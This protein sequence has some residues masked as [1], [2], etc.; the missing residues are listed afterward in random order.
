MRRWHSSKG[1]VLFGS[2]LLLSVAAVSIDASIAEPENKKAKVSG[3]DSKHMEDKHPN[4]KPLADSL[5]KVGMT[6]AEVE[7]KLTV[8]G[9]ISTSF[10][11][12]RYVVKASSTP[13][14]SKVSKVD[15]SFKPAGM[16]DEVYY[17]G[18]WVAAKQS[19]GDVV[20]K[21]SA[22]YEEPPY[23]D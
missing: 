14:A 2:A 20:M 5:V 18:K 1:L 17:L 10:K 19:P 12:E 9:G 22:P 8:D 3:K 15:I 21:V 16:S 11:S 6:R 7:K 4:S 13:G 23:C